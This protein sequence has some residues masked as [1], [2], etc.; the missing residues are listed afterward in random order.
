VS[1]PGDPVWPL[2]PGAARVLY[3]A[4][5]AWRPPAAPLESGPREPDPVTRLVEPLAP[6]ERV[7]LERALRWL[8]WSPRLLLHDRRGLAWLPRARRRA[9]LDRLARRGPP[10]FGPAARRVRHLLTRSRIAA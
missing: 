2:S 6:A 3:A 1:A 10:P 8:E 9:W 7:R 4:L 5:D